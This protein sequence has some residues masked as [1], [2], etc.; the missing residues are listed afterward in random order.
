ME[1]LDVPV[2]GGCRFI[3]TFLTVPSVCLVFR[4]GKSCAGRMSWIFVFRDSEYVVVE[5]GCFR[6]RHSGAVSMSAAK[7][8]DIKRV[9]SI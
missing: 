4:A 7:A 2:G 6:R 1:A 8:I 3:R 9:S 5:A